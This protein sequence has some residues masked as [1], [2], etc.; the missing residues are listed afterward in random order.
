VARGPEGRFRDK[1]MAELKK[2]PNAEFFSVQ[3]KGIR[4]TPDVLSCVNGHFVALEFKS[5]RGRG[6]KL[7]WYFHTRVLSAK[8]VHFF[9]SPRNGEKVY[10]FMSILSRLPRR[11]LTDVET[12][13]DQIINLTK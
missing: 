2:L 6:T 1:F 12:L 11:D 13:Y 9:V 3:Q 5:E 4:A 8:G 7:Q 10:Q